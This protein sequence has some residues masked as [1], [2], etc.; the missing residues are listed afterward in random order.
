MVAVPDNKKNIARRPKIAIKFAVNT[1]NGSEVTAKIAGMES[2]AKIT[3]DA[4]TK[5]NTKNSGVAHNFDIG[6]FFVLPFEEFETRIHQERTE[7]IQNP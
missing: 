7:D 4:S 3:S 6:F 1:I 5:I 2:T